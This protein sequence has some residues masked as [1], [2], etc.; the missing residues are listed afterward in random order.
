MNN[1]TLGILS[2]LVDAAD[3]EPESTALDTRSIHVVSNEQD[4]LVVRSQLFHAPNTSYTKLTLR[5]SL[6]CFAFKSACP[7]SESL[8]ALWIF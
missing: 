1:P 6:K 8:L 5:S 3:P 4:K 2:Y 7:A